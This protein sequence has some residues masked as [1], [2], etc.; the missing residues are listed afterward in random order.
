MKKLLFILPLFLLLVWCSL[1]KWISQ[2]EIFEKELECAKLFDTINKRLNDYNNSSFALTLELNEVFYST[3]LNKCV[4]SDTVWYTNSREWTEWNFL[5]VNRIMDVNI[6][7]WIKAWDF[8]WNKYI[9]DCDI[10]SSNNECE[11]KI[12]DKIKELKWE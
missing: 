9:F 5:W 8:V 11:I 10:I 3:I 1:K 6:Y 7:P 2:S 4:Y 12:T